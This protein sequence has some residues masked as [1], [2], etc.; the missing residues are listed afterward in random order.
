MKKPVLYLMLILA[1]FPV[2]LLSQSKVKG[3]E[4]P[5][6]ILP[7]P[8]TREPNKYIDF[9][10]DVSTGVLKISKHLTINTK[11]V[12]SNCSILATG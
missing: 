4:L 11:D 10:V 5:N 8:Q 6:V 12:F 1:Y 9:P 7:S 2:R 3:Q